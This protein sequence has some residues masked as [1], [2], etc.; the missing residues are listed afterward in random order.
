[1]NKEITSREYTFLQDAYNVFNARLFDGKLPGSLITLVNRPNSAGYYIPA[2]FVHRANADSTD[3]ISLNHAVMDRPDIEV[4]STLA[5]EMTHQEQ[6][7]FGTAPRKG[8]HNKPWAIIMERIGL[9]PS[10]TGEPGGKKT[11]QS[12]T[13]YIQP[14][15]LF[16]IVANEFIE[17]NG[18]FSWKSFDYGKEKKERESKIKYTCPVCESNVWGKSG[19]H[20]V[21]GECETEFIEKL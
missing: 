14:G 3:E 16:E 12:M 5:H 9:I 13:H 6:E 2:K 7:H 19:L 1:M 8:Y 20:I 17:K 21:C 18:C 4:L 11:G 10:S 15:G